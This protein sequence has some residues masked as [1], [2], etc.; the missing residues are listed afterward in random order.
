MTPKGEGLT[1]E[2]KLSLSL[3]GGARFYL[4]DRLG[5]RLDA[6]WFGTF[7]NG[8]GAV[9]CSNG[10]CLLNVQGDTLSQYTATA[11]VVLAF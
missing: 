6:R 9:F 3:G 8:S 10:A 2:T 11:G 4:T 7:F 5:L 1:S